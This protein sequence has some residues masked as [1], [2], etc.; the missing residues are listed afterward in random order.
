MKDIELWQG[1]CLLRYGSWPKPTAIISD[2]AYGLG[3]FPS[4]PN[5]TGDLVEWYRSHVCS[6]SAAATSQT[7]LWFWNTEIGWAHVHPLLEE[8]GWRYKRS[9]VW[10][11]GISHI[12]GNHNS[13]TALSFPCVTEVCVQYVREPVVIL[14]GQQTRTQDWL[15]SEWKRAGLTLAQANE[16]CGVANA[17]SRKYLCRDT[18]WYFPPSDSF[19]ALV[20]FANTFG[21]NDGRPYF[22]LD[23]EIDTEVLTRN[24]QQ[25]IFNC[26]MGITNVWD[27]P[28]ARGGE[29]IKIGGSIV[30]INQKPLAI[31]DL[32]IETST[33]VGDVVWEPFGGLFSASLSAY[34]LG[35][36]PF[37][38]EIDEIFYS[39]GISRFDDEI[40]K[41]RIGG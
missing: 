7:T 35:R 10:N 14:N 16:A 25:N 24:V 13:K 11:K 31:M 17:A 36:K 28:T 29:R 18:A 34:R 5:D 39:A 40:A 22:Q 26:P 41:E 6:W 9:N 30:H 2:G 1:D 12:A 38:A 27:Y 23:S 20:E 19:A 32:I 15:R 21:D 8:Y 37:A 33:N 4:E 3:K